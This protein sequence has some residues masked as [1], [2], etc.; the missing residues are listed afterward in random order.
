MKTTGIILALLTFSFSLFGQSEEALREKLKTNPN[1]AVV[2]YDLGIWLQNDKKYS[3]ATKFLSNACKLDTNKTDYPYSL[4]RV[5]EF[6]IKN[7]DSAMYWY[8]ESGIRL[9]RNNEKTYDN[10][11][12][13]LLEL[14]DAAGNADYY[15]EAYEKLMKIDERF[16]FNYSAKEKYDLLKEQRDH[17]TAATFIKMGDEKTKKIQF[18]EPLSTYKTRFDQGIKA[19][20]KAIQLDPTQKE[21]INKKIGTAMANDAY[22]GYFEQGDF[23]EALK[24]YEAASKYAPKNPEIFSSMGIIKMDKLKT[25]D[26]KGA[27]ANFQKALT[28]TTSA[29][30]K[31]ELYE[32]IGNCYEKQKDYTNAIANYEKGIAQEPNFAKSIHAKL[33]RVYE[34]MGNKAKADYHRLRS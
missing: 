25:P 6:F 4:G 21:T 19:Y 13:K 12:R 7:A 11:W 10:G 30:V 34:A 28:L 24:R 2:N 26:Y 32:Y 17:P 14:S 29:S 27:I 5:Y 33:T 16:Q 23:Q 3:D 1:E 15:M 9:V 22:Y 20:E 31:R 8:R 18:N